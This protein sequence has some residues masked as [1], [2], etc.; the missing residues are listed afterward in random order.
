MLRLLHKPQSLGYRI[1]TKLYQT[2]INTEKRVLNGF[3][4]PAAPWDCKCG[5]GGDHVGI[6]PLKTS[7][8]IY[9]SPTARE[10][11]TQDHV[12]VPIILPELFH[13]NTYWLQ[14]TVICGKDTGGWFQKQ[15][16]FLG[17]SEERL[18]WKVVL[19]PLSRGVR[20]MSQRPGR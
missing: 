3:L 20:S 4:I 7:N 12:L 17:F 14:F 9:F 6:P 8:P 11:F 16:A 5:G 10:L 15:T 1:F 2:W 13:C 19:P 18:W